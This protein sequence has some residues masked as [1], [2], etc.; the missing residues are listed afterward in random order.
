MK[1]FCVLI[2]INLL[3]TKVVLAEES[4]TSVS[5]A[6]PSNPVSTE[7]SLEQATKQ[8]VSGTSGRVLSAKTEDIDGKKVHVIKILT[9]DGRIQQQ[10]VDAQNGAL[11]DKDIK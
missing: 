4:V 3:A 6:L 10:V 1:I 2:L 9:D 11:I 8:V 7:I 5:P